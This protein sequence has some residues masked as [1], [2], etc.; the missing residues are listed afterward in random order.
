M[1]SRS[2]HYYAVSDKILPEIRPFM[3]AFMSYFLQTTGN[4]RSKNIK[5][6]N[7]M[8]WR[9]SIFLGYIDKQ[10]KFTTFRNYLE[11]FSSFIIRDYIQNE[12]GTNKTSIEQF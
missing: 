5:S 8:F 4:K 12:D 2:S 10:T 6:V 9:L 3:A 7:G 1:E 11:N